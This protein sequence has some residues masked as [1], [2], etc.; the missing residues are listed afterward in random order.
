MQGFPYDFGNCYTAYGSDAWSRRFQIK[1]S[2]Q[3][4]DFTDW[5][6]FRGTA[7]HGD[8]VVVLA[9]DDSEKAQ[10]IFRISAPS[11]DD[12]GD[13]LGEVAW[14]WDVKGDGPAGP[15]SIGKGVI[16]WGEGVTE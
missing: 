15:I 5:S 7:K 14:R 4:F 1:S 6:N 9:V 3:P 2:G 16:T 8:R 12:F 11:A 13:E 10:G